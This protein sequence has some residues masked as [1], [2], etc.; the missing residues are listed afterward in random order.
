MVPLSA[1]ADADIEVIDYLSTTLNAEFKVA[2]NWL[3]LCEQG[4]AVVLLDGLDEVPT[5][6]RQSVIRRV[7]RFTA[8][9][10]MSRG[11]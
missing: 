7:E 3:R 2:I 5:E 8:R 1:L 4:L 6:H 11:Y 10:P 9:F